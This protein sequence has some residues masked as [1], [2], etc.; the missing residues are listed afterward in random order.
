MA[1]TLGNGQEL[2]S[3]QLCVGL[4]LSS[5]Q[6]VSPNIAMRGGLGRTSGSGLPS[7][8]A[9]MAPAGTATSQLRT[10][11]CAGLTL[12]NAW[13][14]SARTFI[15]AAVPSNMTDGQASSVM[16]RTLEVPS[17]PSSTHCAR[18]L[19]C[20]AC[21]SPAPRSPAPRSA[22]AAMTAGRKT[23]AMFN[24][25]YTCISIS[26]IIGRPAVRLDAGILDRRPLRREP[27]PE[28]LHL[29]V[30]AMLDPAREHSMNSFR[31]AALITLLTCA[32]VLIAAPA[33]AQVAYPERPV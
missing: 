11:N 25:G 21:G 26:P 6:P 9:A 27:S 7:S 2:I 13:P 19:A 23:R 17:G 15:G 1:A 18:I 10:G 8:S 33:R 30:D 32:L 3:L 31:P 5:R 28:L 29:I 20:A 4:P 24:P 14:G 16:A 12:P 22:T